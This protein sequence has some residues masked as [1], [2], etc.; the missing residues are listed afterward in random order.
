APDEL[1]RMV[2]TLAPAPAAPAAGL[3]LEAFLGARFDERRALTGTD[4]VPASESELRFLSRS[5]VAP[6]LRGDAASPGRRAA[7]A[8][9]AALIGYDLVA[10]PD[11]RGDGRACLVLVER[12]GQARRIGW[13]PPVCTRGTQ[14]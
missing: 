10:L 13:G 5:L 12:D 8:A 6:L 7:L 9:R 14:P 11:C 2:A 3:G 4:H 1:A